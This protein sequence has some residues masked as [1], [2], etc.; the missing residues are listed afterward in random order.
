M[1]DLSS[2]ISSLLSDPD[3]MERIRSMAESVLGGGEE[4]EKPKNDVPDIDFARLLPMISRLKSP[5]ND[6]RTELLLALRP[7]LS[8]MRQNRVD[9]AIKL[10]RIVD[11]LPLLKESGIFD[12]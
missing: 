2:R 1:D 10:L 7:H 5:K 11:M 12:F 6:K 9:S 4:P 3:S 8:E